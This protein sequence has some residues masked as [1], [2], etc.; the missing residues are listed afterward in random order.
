VIHPG[1]GQ[2]TVKIA[3]P[4]G[5]TAVNVFGFQNPGAINANVVADTLGDLYETAFASVFG[6]D[7]SIGP[8][9]VVWNDTGTMKEGD[10]LTITPGT[11]VA[12]MVPPNTA[13][14]FKKATGL[15]G[16]QFRGRTYLPSVSE[17]EVDDA[18]VLTPAT[19][20]FLQTQGNAF[21]A[22]MISANLPMLVLHANRIDHTTHLPIPG[23]APVGTLVTLFNPEA[24]VA[25][26]RRRLRK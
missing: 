5:R 1:D 25:T 3:M 14:L 24:V 11:N 26:Q 20:L 18:G 7:Y 9:H 12:T 17:G 4:N 10:D 19:L 23:T 6:A 8:H 21:L 13:V 16:K 15:A 22:S 2:W